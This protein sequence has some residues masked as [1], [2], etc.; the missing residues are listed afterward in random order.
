MTR[1]FLIV[2][3]PGAG[4]TVVAKQL[5]AEQRALRLTPDEW[6]LPLFGDSKAH[7]KRDVL[8]GRLIAPG[9]HALQLGTSVVLDRWRAQFEAPDADELG[10]LPV[11]AAPP[12]W[13]GWPA[14][15]ADRWPPVY[16]DLNLAI[17]SRFTSSA[18]RW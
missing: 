4:G 16:S 8:E 17:Q 5:A 10:D 15:A 13:S 11:P 1:L 12:G 3:L 14:W 2:G 18:W 6:M 9:F 7:G